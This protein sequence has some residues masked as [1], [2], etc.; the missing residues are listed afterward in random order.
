MHPRC[1]L[2]LYNKYTDYPSESAI[3]LESTARI[4]I[5]SFAFAP[6]LQASPAPLPCISRILHGPCQPLD[7]IPVSLSP[8]A[9]RRTCV[10]QASLS[11]GSRSHLLPAPSLPR[12]AQASLSTATRSYLLLALRDVPAWPRPASWPVPGLTF[13]LQAKRKRGPK[14]PFPCSNPTAIRTCASR[15][16]CSGL[17]CWSHR[18]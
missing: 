2:H 6:P 1:V 11:A 17:H 5:Y 12:M 14:A 3:F 13:S 8:C 15:P 9:P 4:T 7:R 10:A 18:D 16:A